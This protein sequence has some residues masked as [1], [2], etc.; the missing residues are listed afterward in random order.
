VRGGG[1]GGGSGKRNRYRGSAWRFECVA[2][3]MKMNNKK[4]GFVN[5]V[6]EGGQGGRKGKQ[7]LYR[8][9]ARGFECGARVMKMCG[10]GCGD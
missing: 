5:K 9:R 6:R 1:Q 2:R 10:K 7:N 3:V 8:G 4:I